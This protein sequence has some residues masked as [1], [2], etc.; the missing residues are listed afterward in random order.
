[1]RPLEAP[2]RL[3]AQQTAFA[4]HLRDPQSAPPP[5]GVEPRRMAVYR[6]L[7]YGT[8]EGL[9]AGGFP[10]LRQLRGDDFWHALVRDF[11][12]E[13]VSHTPLFPQIGSEF[14][15]YLEARGERA[16]DPPFLLELAHYEWVELA[17]TNEPDE[18]PAA[19]IDPAGDLLDGVPVV[20]S[21]A[22]PLAYRFPVQQ[23]RPDHQPDQPP[24]QPTL[25]LL[26]RDETD[27]VQFKLLSLVGFRLLQSLADNPSSLSGRQVLQL[28]AAEA[29]SDDVDRFVADGAGLLEQLRDR[30]AIV[31]S[32][33]A[34]TR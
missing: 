27:R 7:F 5:D 14:L 15:R 12:R 11:Y 25:L 20:S 17:L 8:I 31:G 30:R 18:V 23:I 1:M 10:V 4:A 19:D 33:P 16:G 24:A 22:W 6:E 2:A 3:A 28:L 9:L 13:H 34:P 32:T 21:L 29:S 26:V